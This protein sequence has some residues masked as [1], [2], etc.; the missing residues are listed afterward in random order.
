MLL[1]RHG[2][3]TVAWDQSSVAIRALSHRAAREGV[4][5]AAAVRDVVAV[6][7]SDD[8]FDVIVV[9]HFLERALSAH[10][11]GALRPGGLLYYQ[12]FVRDS[13]GQHGPS[14]PAYRLAENE[15]LSLFVPPLRLRVYREEG[16]LGDTG[17]GSRDLAQMVAQKS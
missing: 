13:V 17:A 12:T 9:A 11:I 16:T 15:L 4:E 2:L 5:V 1:A 10:L 3:N 6:P 8:D 7:P 14:N